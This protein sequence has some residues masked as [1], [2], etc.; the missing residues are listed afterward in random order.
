MG[1]L[2]QAVLQQLKKAQ[3]ETNTRLDALL[4]EQ[5]RTNEL[6]ARLV[7]LQSAHGAMP[8]PAMPTTTTWGRG[9]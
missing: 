8:A 6:L 1:M 5:Q 2:D 7:A 9:V 4:A 3:G